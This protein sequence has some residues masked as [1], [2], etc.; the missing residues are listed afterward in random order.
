[1]KREERVKLEHKMMTIWNGFWE[2]AIDIALD[3]DIK[4]KVNI[5]NEEVESELFDLYYKIYP[6]NVN[7]KIE[8]NL[9][10]IGIVDFQKKL[11]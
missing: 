10:Y 5:R 7:E 4:E 1:M 2:D 6:N 11:D 3:L 9:M 8:N